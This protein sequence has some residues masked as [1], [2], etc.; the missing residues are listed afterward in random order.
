M[1][2][3]VLGSGSKG[4]AT[5]VEAE[6]KALLIDNGFSGVEIERRLEAKGLDGG[7]LQGILLTHE[8]GDHVRGAAILAR[9]HGISLYANRGTLEAA[10]KTL[11]NVPDIREFCTGS[12]FCLNKF[13]IHPFAVSHDTADPVGFV[14]RSG[15]CSLGYCTD[16]GMV[17]RLIQH[18]LTG[19][20]GLIIECNHDPVMLKNG[21]YPLHLQ[22]RVRSHHGHLANE[23]AARFIQ[24]LLHENLQHVVLAHISETNNAPSLAYD[25][26]VGIISSEG[27]SSLPEISL[28]WQDKAGEIVSLCTS[29]ENEDS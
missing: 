5:Y 1:R 14:I 8:H 12:S 22:Q 26:V 29:D 17:S 21:P 4:N 20:H 27:G 9:K 15:S 11:G 23:D 3:C 13:L 18:R 24:D 7:R 25:T 19:C 16:T 6:G 10:A 2:F 28:A